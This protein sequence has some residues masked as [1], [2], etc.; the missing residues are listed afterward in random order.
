M[1]ADAPKLLLT[2]ASGYIGARC[3]SRL[4]GDGFRVTALVRS[5]R[6]AA[7][8]LAKGASAAAV[9]DLADERWDWADE[10]L[11]DARVVV[12]GAAMMDFFPREPAALRRV[13]VEGTRRLA[14]AAVRA[15]VQLFV[16]V[17]STEAMG[18]SP[19]DGSP[20]DEN[21]PL[22]PTS[23][24]GA[25]KVEAERAVA[26][27][28]HGTDTRFVVL[29]L[30]G[31]TGDGDAFVGY[32][33]LESIYYGVLCVVP[34]DGRCGLMFLHID[35]AVAAVSLAARAPPRALDQVII[36]APEAA[37]SYEGWLRALHRMLDRAG[38]FFHAPLPL[39]RAAVR[40]TERCK[41]SRFLWHADTVT[42]MGEQRVYSNRRAA[43]LLDFRPRFTVAEALQDLVDG[44][45]ERG[46]FPL[47]PWDPLSPLLLLL[48]AATLLAALAVAFTGR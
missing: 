39:L 44:W 3:V 42:R 20:A 43:R 16:F 17:S 4:A 25:S 15:R 45:R 2:G 14:A 31:V 28:C 7:V 41:R 18:P 40:A 21:S 23:L 9:G 8:A 48:I 22:R 6:D 10:A 46:D 47:R 11:R 13:N 1:A 34:G 32:E 24:Y 36:A 38:P 29:R 37:L 27:E 19:P 26:S 12:H 35:D 30:T 33:L 5:Q